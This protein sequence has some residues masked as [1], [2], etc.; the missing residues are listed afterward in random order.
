M[1]EIYSTLSNTLLSGTRGDDIIKNGGWLHYDEPSEEWH[2]GGSNV[3]IN[4][5]AGNDYVYSIGN[6]VT[7]NTGAGNDSVNN[8]GSSVTINTGA[9]NDSVQNGYG[10]SSV[11]INTGTGNDSVYNSGSSV[12]I[13]TGA[14]NDSVIN[15]GDFVTFTEGFTDDEG[16]DSILSYSDSF[17]IG[18]GAVSISGGA[19]DDLVINGS[20]SVTIKGGKGNDYID[21]N[22]YLGYYGGI[23]YYSDDDHGSNVVFEYASGDGNDIIY[24]FM[25]DSTLSIGG[26]SYSTKKSGDDIIV[27]VGTGKISLMG[28]ASLDKVN[29]KGT[30]TSSS[31]NNIFS[32]V[33]V[34]DFGGKSKK[35]VRNKAL[36]GFETLLKTDMSDVILKNVDGIKTLDDPTR[37]KLSSLSSIFN[38]A[39]KANDG[40]SILGSLCSSAETF[41]GLVKS[42]KRDANWGKQ[43]SDCVKNLLKFGNSVLKIS[44]KE[45]AKSLGL[46]LGG[47]LFGLA[48]SIIATTDGINDKE[49]DNIV[50]DLF[51]V[52]GEFAKLIIP[53]AKATSMEINLVVATASALYMGDVQMQKSLEQS[54]ANGVLYLMPNFLSAK[55]DSVTVS[56]DEFARKMTLSASDVFLNWL[57]EKTGGNAY[58]DMTYAEKAAEGYKILHRR[59]LIGSITLANNISNAIGNWW[60]KITDSFSQKGVNLKGDSKNN[61]LVGGAKKDTMSG[62]AGDDKLFGG[63]GNDSLSGGDGKDTLSGGSGNDK[64]I[65]GAGNDSLSGGDGAD[66]LSGGTGD[67]KLFGNAGNDSLSG[68]DGKDTLS[69]GTGNDKLLGGAGNDSLSGGDGKDTLS[70]SSGNDKL[71]G[72]AGNDSLSGGSDKDTLSGGSGNDKLL[73]GSGNDCI[74]GGTGNDSLWGGTGNDTLWGDDG[75][76]NFYYAKGD[77]NDVIFGFE[78]GDTLTIDNIAFKTSMAS[79]DN[80]SGILTLNLSGGSVTFKEFTASTFNINGS[81]YKISGTTLAKK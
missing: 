48:G 79:Y 75:K 4:S 67:D 74:K 45:L 15:G 73:G 71:F 3:T 52:S 11:T 76:D 59:L 60:T 5:G 31:S 18:G 42:E 66:T 35:S 80:S 28:A 49:R 58:S 10:C 38:L 57:D 43:V 29:I 44:D 65:G 77:G 16:N 22:C 24:G 39:G 1:A 78:T 6:K 7:I 17:S 50:K 56:L 61:L 26:G 54:P 40:F 23:Y 62:N 55:I 72:G 20:N 12:T 64:L 27:T 14:G 33:N 47:S 37:K 21:N 2:D 68:G 36:T 8:Y 19:G 69:G 53:T 51:S 30:K 63:A 34:T 9:G 25:A 46:G 32:K 41:L 81:A 70:G 13:N